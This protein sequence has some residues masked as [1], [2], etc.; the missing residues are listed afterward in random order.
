MKT[1]VEYIVRSLV[2]HPEEVQV[3]ESRRS[4]HIILEMRV[5]REDMG[6]VIGKRGRVVNAIRTLL[7]VLAGREGCRVTLEVLEPR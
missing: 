7:R 5:S 2:E 3:H 6:R 4:G 1:L